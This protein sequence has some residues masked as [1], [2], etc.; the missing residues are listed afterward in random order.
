MGRAEGGTVQESL[1]ITEGFRRSRDFGQ[2]QQG[3][4]KVDGTFA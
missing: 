1:T 3:V 4:V 2:L